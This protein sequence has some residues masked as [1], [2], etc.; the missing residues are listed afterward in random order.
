[1]VPG[2]NAGSQYDARTCIALW[3][4]AFLLII[5]IKIIDETDQMLQNLIGLC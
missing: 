5:I 4:D 2:V 3:H 1:M